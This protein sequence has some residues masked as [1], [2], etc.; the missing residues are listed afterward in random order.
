MSQLPDLPADY[1]E[2]VT[3]IKERVRA[4]RLGA[5][6]AANQELLRRYSEIGSEI[7]RRQQQQ[8]WGAKVIDRL[9]A[10]LRTAFPGVK[11]FSSRSLK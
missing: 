2:F 6:A 8:G 10:D 4:A 3:A 9:P 7:L 5:V 11:G 1:E